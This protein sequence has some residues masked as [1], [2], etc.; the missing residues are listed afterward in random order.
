M[1]SWT[2]YIGLAGIMALL[3]YLYGL[4]GNAQDVGQFGTSAIL[5][6]IQYWNAPGAD[7]SYGWFIP[8]VCAGIVLTKRRELWTAPQSSH[9]IGLVV[10]ILSLALH[11]FGVRTQQTII[12]LLSL[13]GLLWGI[14][15]YL[16]GWAVAKI[17]LFPCAYLLFCI[18]PGMLD[19]L[20]VPLRIMTSAV[21]THVLN[22]LGVPAIRQGTLILS[23]N[24]GGFRLGVDDPCSGLRSLMAIAAL[25]SVYAYFL[26]MAAWK[27][28]ILFFSA[29]PLAIIGN[30]VRVI[31]VAIA[32][33][34]L[35]QERAMGFYHD[36][37]GYVVFAIAIL[38]TMGVGRGLERLSV[39]RLLVWIRIH[40]SA[41]SS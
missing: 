26:H 29:L 24:P 27:K 8:V 15:F 37:S 12:S 23:A 39:E 32:A 38:L 1:K 13:I 30:V 40:K 28:V 14:P 31:A 18:P 3:G 36:Y 10:V 22:G 33:G 21:S 5:W 2:T 17:L 6:M 7:L 4:R 35:G 41:R 11:W 20:T 16:Y 19:S 25:T 34:I 9:W